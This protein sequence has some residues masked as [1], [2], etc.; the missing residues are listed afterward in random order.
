MAPS[1]PDAMSIPLPALF[2]HSI[3]LREKHL[4]ISLSVSSVV[5]LWETVVGTLATE[6]TGAYI[7][8]S[9]ATGATIV[10]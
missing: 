1:A 4:F 8:G 3:A 2:F 5:F 9:L 7:G 6:A 10:G